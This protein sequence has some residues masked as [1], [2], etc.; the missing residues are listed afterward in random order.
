MTVA[1]RD[2]WPA[3]VAVSD[4][5]MPLAIMKH[6][7]GQLRARTSGLLEA[8]V[9]TTKGEG[10]ILNHEFWI[11]A[12]A[13]NRYRFLLFSIQHDPDFVYPVTVVWRP[14]PP[15]RPGLSAVQL[16]KGIVESLQ[17]VVGFPQASS[18]NEF[19]DALTKI[20]SDRK[21]KRIIHSL[22]ARINE[23]EPVDR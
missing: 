12:P 23:V 21:T 17:E 1:V 9:K 8:E 6:Q 4:A 15:D 3:D 20:F 2:L 13:L 5:I 22:I 19:E 14:D 18:R 16:P 7:A 11:V 10:G